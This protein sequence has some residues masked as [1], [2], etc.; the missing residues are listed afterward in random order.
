MATLQA[1]V[2]IV[3]VIVP[4]AKKVNSPVA[5]QVVFPKVMLPLMF[6][7]P[8]DVK[9]RTGAPVVRLW[10]FS[11][12]VKVMVPVPEKLSNTTSSTEVGTVPVPPVPLEVLAQ[13]VVLVVF[14]VPVP[15]TQYIVAMTNPI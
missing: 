5:F 6:N 7:V 13:L 10:Q 1:K 8:V 12:P 15:P 3:V 4:V 2:V 9:V 14:H 11:A